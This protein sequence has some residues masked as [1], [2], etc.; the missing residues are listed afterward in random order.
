MTSDS[1]EVAMCDHAADTTQGLLTLSQAVKILPRNNGR[2]IHTST[3]WRWTR[4]LRG[5]YL[6]YVRVGR[7][8]MVTEDGLYRFFADLMKQDL[9]RARSS[10]LKRRRRCRNYDS[11]RQRAIQESESIL[12]RAK[13]LV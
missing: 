5:V 3:L 2:H 10:K 4:G 13:I 8:I 9:E 11:Q 12:R 1:Q 7:L 6:Q